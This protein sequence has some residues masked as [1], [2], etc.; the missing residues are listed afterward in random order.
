MPSRSISLRIKAKQEQGRKMARARWD[1]DRA[2]RDTEMLERIQELAEIEMMN[3]PRKQGDILGSLQWT[4]ARTGRI[5]RWII[6]IGDRID[7]IT[8]ESMDGKQTSSHGW[9]WVLNSLRP[10][11]CGRECATAKQ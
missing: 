10:H 5:R 11:L 8:M 1:A 4:D 2:R 7:R 3:L 9:A 6:R